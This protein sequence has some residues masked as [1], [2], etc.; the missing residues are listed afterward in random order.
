MAD[1]QANFQPNCMYMLEIDGIS[2]MSF[3]KLA[4]N[5]SEWSIIEG[6]AGTDPLYKTTSSGLKT[7]QTITIEK[8]LRVGEVDDVKELINWHMAGSNTKK[9]GAVVLLDR[10]KAEIMRFNFKQ[11]WVS[12]FT[13]PDLEGRADNTA[14]VFGFELAV[15]GLSVA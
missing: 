1:T 8:H 6:R 4:I 2:T 13:P 12:K 11:A 14:M 15:A 5:G 10:D 9:T 7:N 3:E